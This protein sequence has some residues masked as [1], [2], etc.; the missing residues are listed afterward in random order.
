MIDLKLIR[1]KP[2]MVREAIASLQLNAPIDDIL[3][4]DGQRRALLR[5]VEQLKARRNT[6]SKEIGRLRGAPE[7][8]P[9]KEEMRQV[10]ARIKA[11]DEQMRETDEHLGGAMMEV[12]NLPHESVPVG[13]D[14]SENVI[15]RTEGEPRVFEFE[16]LPHWELGTSLGM[17][18]FERGVKM[19]GTRFYV[20]R[21]PGARLQRALITWMRDLHTMQHDYT[22]N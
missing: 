19:S 12:P 17:I 20:L 16:P 8:E 13:V 22:E 7:T 21:G 9:L 10:G 4:L 2:E 1:E 18:D 5:E 3:S 15:V 6:V 14:E 11:L